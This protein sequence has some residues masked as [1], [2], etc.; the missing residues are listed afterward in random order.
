M[1]PPQNSTELKKELNRALDAGELTL[2]QA[3]RQMRKIVGMTQKDYAKK[4]L[5]I[6]PRILM[7]IENEKGNPTL[8]TL[9]KIGKPFGYDIGFIKRN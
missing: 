6:T 4:V 2:G 7:A 9:R 3:T 5:N 8:D 1:K